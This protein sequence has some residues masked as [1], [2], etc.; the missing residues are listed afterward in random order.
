MGNV[1]DRPPHAIGSSF[2]SSWG[3]AGAGIWG[4]SSLLPRDAAPPNPGSSVAWAHLERQQRNLTRLAGFE[5]ARP[6]GSGALTST[7]EADPWGVRSNAWSVPEPTSGRV[8]PGNNSPPRVRQDP[9]LADLTKNA[10]FYQAPSSQMQSTI[11]QPRAGTMPRPKTGSA[12]DTAPNSYRYAQFQ[13]FQDEKVDSGHFAQIRRDSDQMIPSY[14]AEKR[15]GPESTY[16]LVGHGRDANPS[17]LDAS[18][19]NTVYGGDMYRDHVANTL[20]LQKTVL[21]GAAVFPSHV[22]KQAYHHNHNV[23]D[24]DLQAQMARTLAL[25]DGTASVDGRGGRTMYNGISG[26]AFQFNPLTQPWDSMHGFA[27]QV[28]GRDGNSDAFGTPFAKRGPLAAD[29]RNS[30]AFNPCPGL[31]NGQRSYGGTPQ[32]GSEVWIQPAS[33]DPRVG[34]E[35]DRRGQPYIPQ[36]PM[37]AFFG[38]PGY[39]AQPFA[40]YPPPPFDPYAPVFRP[41]MHM[42]GAF[43]APIH[44]YLAAGTSGILSFPQR[45][46]KDQDLAKGI[47]SALLEEFRSSSRSTRRF[48]LKVSHYLPRKC[49]FIDLRCSIGHLRPH[50]G[51]QR[52]SAR[53]SLYSNKTGD[54][55]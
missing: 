46:G 5:D 7:S 14:R 21:G 6:T 47:R 20:P 12:V 45:P 3:Q 4:N 2:G 51:V 34:L 10:S 52:R 40:P 30:S 48:E 37:T 23:V 42:T 54:G 36:Q 53:V 13:D 26:Q 18:T 22:N 8:A 44:G 55:Q 25:H 11:G 43:G 50:S 17:G 1:N 27:V 16:M 31:Q 38:H 32:A 19:S 28:A 15:V 29:L 41:M 35:F 24:D 9:G 33:R 49:H 39:Y